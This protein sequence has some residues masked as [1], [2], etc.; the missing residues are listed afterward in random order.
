MES[1]DDLLAQVKAEYQEQEQAKPAKKPLIFEEDEFKPPSSSLPTYQTHAPAKNWSSPFEDSLLA[2]LKAEFK[3]QEQAE[4]LK[5]QQQQREEQLRKEQQLREEQLRA[6]QRRQRR[7]EA[8]TQEA[9]EWLKNLN[10]RSEEGRWF[11]EF[12]YSYPSKLEAAIDYL[13]ALR[14]TH[15]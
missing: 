12:S 1:I 13:E 15:R 4:E 2:E 14:E 6:E 9:T 10:P 7:R 5:R 11:E 3:E 8:L